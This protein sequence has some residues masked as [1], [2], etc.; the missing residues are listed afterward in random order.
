MY[1]VNVG[2]SFDFV[3]TVSCVHDNSLTGWQIFI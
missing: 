1:P 3:M 2:I